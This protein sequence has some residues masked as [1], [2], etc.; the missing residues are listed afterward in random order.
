M[1]DRL[2]PEEIKAIEKRCEAATMGIWEMEESPIGYE[3]APIHE[4]GIIDWSEEIFATAGTGAQDKANAEFAVTAHNTDIP[5]LL[6]DRKA[7]AERIRDL[8]KALGPFAECSKS[9]TEITEPE[10]QWA[11]RESVNFRE[12]RGVTFADFLNA[13][14]AASGEG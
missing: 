7:Q 4:D 1:T 14:I 9:M 11:W 3:I 2:T 12:P 5:R 6:A 13:H 10:N 8:E